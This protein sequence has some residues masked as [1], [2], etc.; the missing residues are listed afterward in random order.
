[1]EVLQVRMEC[2]MK[3][4]HLLVL[5]RRPDPPPHSIGIMSIPY[6]SKPPIDID[7]PSSSRRQ[8]ISRLKPRTEGD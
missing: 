3:S 5:L 6:L 8:S 4:I 2:G 1:M 7:L